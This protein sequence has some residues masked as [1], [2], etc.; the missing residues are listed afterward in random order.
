MS[1]L[2]KHHAKRTIPSSTNWESVVL[3]SLIEIADKVI[4]ESLVQGEWPVQH[5]VSSCEI[6]RAR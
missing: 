4:S 2:R 5:R 6:K 3:L 1:N